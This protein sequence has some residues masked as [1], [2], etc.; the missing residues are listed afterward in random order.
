MDG[1]TCIGP[2]IATQK[3]AVSDAQLI[4]AADLNIGS[5]S[6]P[7]LNPYPLARSDLYLFNTA[8]NVFFYVNL[9]SH[10]NLHVR[11]ALP[12]Q[13]QTAYCDVNWVYDAAL[14]VLNLTSVSCTGSWTHGWINVIHLKLL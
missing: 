13:S 14:E 8:D 12:S 11:L 7:N 10:P 9:I 6:N 3:Y 2:A 1:I 5:P 4:Y